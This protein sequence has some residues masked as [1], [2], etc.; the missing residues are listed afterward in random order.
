MT[1]GALARLDAL[2]ARRPPGE[3]GDHPQRRGARPV[4][5]PRGRRAVVA[6]SGRVLHWAPAGHGRGLRGAGRLVALHRP[7]GRSMRRGR[8]GAPRDRSV[9]AARAAAARAGRGRRLALRTH[10]GA[11]DDRGNGAPVRRV[12]RR[13]V[14]AEV[15]K[16]R[17]ERG[18]A[19]GRLGRGAR[20]HPDRLIPP[21]RGRRRALALPPA[22][23]RARAGRAASRPL[24]PPPPRSRSPRAA[25]S[26]PRRPDD[27]ARPRAA[28][29]RRSPPPPDAA[30]SGAPRPRG[31]PGQRSMLP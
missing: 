9:G 4:A 3:R 25:P 11:G 29:P 8:R 12:P 23:L 17:R 28:S 5:S 26:P 21:R 27:A 6:A 18:C 30:P 20:T 14:R 22:R 31:A 13:G 15:P 10:R 16:E 2:A 1:R 24:S 19:R 7:P